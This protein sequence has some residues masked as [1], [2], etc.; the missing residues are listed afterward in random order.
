MNEKL[1][2]FITNLG[3]L[4]ETWSIVYK[5]FLAQG[6]GAKEALLHTQSF[7]TTFITGITNNDGGKK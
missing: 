1:N 3:V 6:M 2:S 4:C 5:N 7:M